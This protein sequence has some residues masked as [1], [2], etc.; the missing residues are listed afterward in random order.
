MIEG[1][2]GLGVTP[3]VR[4]IS[5][6]LIAAIETTCRRHEIEC[7]R[8][9]RPEEEA[10]VAA[11]LLVGLPHYYDGDFTGLLDAPRRARRIAWFGEPLPPRGETREM[12]TQHLMGF[13][14]PARG[15]RWVRAVAA[16]LPLPGPVAGLVAHAWVEREWARNLTVIRQA[17]TRVD[18]VVTTS[19][20]RVATLAANGVDARC[21]PFGYHPHFGGA[22]T[23]HGRAA[24]DIE[25]LLLGSQSGL[26]TTRRARLYKSVVARLEPRHRLTWVDGVWGSARDA[27]LRR[28]NILLDIHRVPGNFVGLRLVLGLAAG[29][30]VLTEPMDDPRPFVPGIH[31]VEAPLEQLADEARALLAD[32][33]R[34]RSIVEAGQALLTDAVSMERSLE[35]VLA[36]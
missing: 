12:R 17:A 16:R 5:D 31:Y 28:T 26:R 10:E 23:G 22:L 6:A 2:L 15:R 34:R 21:V 33:R 25:L 19:H 13:R 35:R 9:T 27:L 20:D 7:R 1:P 4:P 32:E 14:L 36:P 8:V 29:A 11:L 3:V 24:R 30:V 18:L